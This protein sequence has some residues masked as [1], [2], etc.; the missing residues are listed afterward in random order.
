MLLAHVLQVKKL[1]ETLVGETKGRW[2]LDLESLI[3]LI[4]KCRRP[5]LAFVSLQSEVIDLSN[6]RMS[7]LKYVLSLESLDSL[8]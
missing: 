1:F 7:L 5:R 4:K 2:R 8:G 6:F 3:T